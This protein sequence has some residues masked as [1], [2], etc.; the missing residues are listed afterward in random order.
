[1]QEN[2]NILLETK[3]LSVDFQV[4]KKS[5]FEKR[6]ILSAVSDVSIEIRK[7]ET[8]GIVGESGC[9]KSTFAN[10]TLGFVKPT[11]GEV[12]F[13]GKKL[14]YSDK[15]ML[16]QVRLDMQK[17][18]QDPNASLNP[19]FTVRDAVC[20]PMKIRGGFDKETMEAKARKMIEAVGLLA[21]DLDRYT[22]EFSGGQQQRIAIARALILKPKYIVCDEPVSALDV[23]VHAQ[24]LNLLMELQK[25]TQ[26][27]YVFIS[28]NL[29]VVK[30]I[31]S[32]LAIMYL[33]KV[34]EYGDADKIFANPKHPYT[35]ALLSAVLEIEPQKE[36]TR[37]VLNGDISSPINPPQGCRFC[38]R[39]YMA[40]S[41]CTEKVCELVEIEPNHYV[42][43]LY[44]KEME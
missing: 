5:F 9:G 7:G 37:I 6:K 8:F 12:Y 1:M 43:C 33:G 21:E 11:A 28:H 3:K 40:K 18:F 23:S 26:T 4:K 16:R 2:N 30:K 36:K 20:E 13:A 15:K 24:I 42:A 14:D 27:T 31:C 39:C 35:K 19:R 17:I 41:D 22:V 38:S 34:V 29:A 32:R 25:K 10:A 44:A